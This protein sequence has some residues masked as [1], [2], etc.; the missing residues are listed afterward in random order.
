MT[1]FLFA[2]VCVFLIYKVIKLRRKV[3]NLLN[4]N[5]QLRDHNTYLVTTYED[6]IRNL[7]S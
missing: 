7:K 5:Q 3:S 4:T 6:M 2:L 1:I